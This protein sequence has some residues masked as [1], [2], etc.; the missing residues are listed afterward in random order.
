MSP[1]FSRNDRLRS[2]VPQR[3]SLEGIPVALRPMWTFTILVFTQLAF[4]C[5]TF[6]DWR[7]AGLGLTV[8]ILLV[9]FRGYTQRSESV[10]LRHSTLQTLTITAVIL[11]S[12]A[13]MFPMRIPSNVGSDS[14]F[15]QIGVDIVAHAS[16]LSTIVIWFLFP[17]R[18]HVTLL[19]LGMLLV[20]LCVAAGGV[21]RSLP[22]QTTVGLVACLGF[23]SAARLIIPVIQRDKA[24]LQEYND[25]KTPGFAEQT[26]VAPLMELSNHR[27]TRAAQQK[28]FRAGVATATGFMMVTGAV[29][30]V[31]DR[32][33]PAVRK[34]LQ[35]QLQ[36]SFDV[37]QKQALVGGMGYVQGST[38]GEIRDYLFNDPAG[39][40]L[41]VYS[42][43]RPGYLRG[44]VFDV[45]DENKWSFVVDRTRSGKPVPLGFQRHEVSSSG[46]GTT[47]LQSG[48]ENRLKRF[49]LQET[50][51]QG[52]GRQ[53]MSVLEIHG[54]AQRGN[55]AFL[56]LSTHWLEARSGGLLVNY[57]DVIEYGLDVKNPYV[58][59]VSMGE[60]SARLVESQR[61]RMTSVDS[62]LISIVQDLSEEL[63]SKDSSNHE[64][65]AAIS[66]YFQ[67]QFHYG[68]TKPDRP[69]KADP[70]L[71]FLEH[72]HEAHCEYFATATALLLRAADVPTRYVTG[73][74]VD[75][76]DDDEECWL[77]RNRHAHA[78]VE[79]YDDQSQTWFAVESTPGRRYFTVDPKEGVLQHSEMTDR[80]DD[81]SGDGPFG[82]FGDLWGWLMSFRTTSLLFTLYTYGQVLVLIGLVAWFVRNLRARRKNALDPEDQR[83]Q[84]LLAKI[85]RQLRRHGFI[86]DP[87]ETLHR[88]ANRIESSEE[89]AAVNGKWNPKKMAIWLRAY[90]NA[91]YQGEAAPELSSLSGSSD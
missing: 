73:Y 75:E 71:Y 19:F 63:C 17:R 55:K 59:G 84:R 76:Y 18:G 91:R 87:G 8:L 68:F 67:S 23:V 64:K 52:A 24:K 49:P 39:V 61:E 3:M 88:F 48:R 50:A 79:A 13:V 36:A 7:T 25:R 51:G 27:Q 45:Y 29:A 16:L 58:A 4:L 70:L 80:E 82:F 43:Q 77:G 46:P 65:A 47:P 90:A 85:N 83:S 9:L 28:R 56:P 21:S 11:I 5:S 35:R 54:D 15:V 6:A 33:L 37:T 74:V 86:R 57:H 62:D 22:A 53:S 78:W 44:T 41:T 69:P 31:T 38:I 89:E 12:L 2:R 66:Q 40:A 42:T 20:L 60:V 34:D 1:R 10:L 72:K 14:N 81:S 32:I 30:N 26:D